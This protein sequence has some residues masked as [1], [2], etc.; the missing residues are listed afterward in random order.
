MIK[1]TLEQAVRQNQFLSQRML[2]V[3]SLLSSLGSEG[4]NAKG[5]SPDMLLSF[6]RAAILWEFAAVVA[7]GIIP[8]DAMIVVIQMFQKELIDKA[9][10]WEKTIE[11]HPEDPKLVPQ[12][13][14]VHDRKLIHIA[15]ETK[16]YDVQHCNLIEESPKVFEG[17]SYNLAVPVQ[18]E[19][20]KIQQ[21][22][23]DAADRQSPRN[24]PGSPHPSDSAAGISRRPAGAGGAGVG[25]PNN[26]YGARGG[27]SL[28]D[29]QQHLKQNDGSDRVG[30]N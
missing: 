9:M 1:L 28:K 20:L 18:L 16:F 3:Q 21:E 30:D 8:Q 17:V 23:K 24:T 2:V 27:R 4:T 13:L 29:L 25:P 14:A 19:W 6:P 26:P 15:G 5:L 12:V 11:E 22:S 10:Y 7:R